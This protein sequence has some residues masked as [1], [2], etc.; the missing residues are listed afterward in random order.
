MPHLAVRADAN[1]TMGVGHAMRCLALTQEW[2]QRGGEVTW[3][4]NADNDGLMRRLDDAQVQVEPLT[5]CCPDPQ[6]IEA[7]LATLARHSDGWLVL[8][9]YH[10]DHCY[11]QQVKEAGHHLLVVDD[12][13]NSGHYYA[14]IVLNQNIDAELLSYHTEPYTQMLLGT[15]YAL[16]RQEYAPWRDWLREI[17]EV[18]RHVLVS[19]GGG[20]SANYTLKVM[21]AL[22]RIDEASLEVVVV[23]GPANPNLEQLE[24]QARSSTRPE[25]RLAQDVTDM[26]KLM[27]WADV[28]VSVGGSTCWELAF[29]GLPSLTLLTHDNHRVVVPGLARAGAVQNLGWI[30]EITEEEL[31]RRVCMV[32]EDWGLRCSMSVRGR[33]L[34]DGLGVER[35]VGCLRSGVVG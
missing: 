24:L 1:A 35:V 27:A 28:A 23:V 20:D 16:L 33:E 15:R 6:D 34:V 2:R 7:T 19:L 11:Q 12:I 9:G 31:T 3:V 32:L 17:P 8:D 21:Q 18:P 14:D 25:I 13:V 26:P 5:G 22:Q 30:T 10:F 4:T 29:M